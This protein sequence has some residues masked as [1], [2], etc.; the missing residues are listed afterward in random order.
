MMKKI[1]K[2]L[3]KRL[4][5]GIIILFL[6]GLSLFLSWSLFLP[7]MFRV[8]DYVHAARIT[9]V[10][11][12]LEAGHFPVRWSD[13]F[14]F[15]YGMP[16][17]LFYA[18]LPYYFGSLMYWLSENLIFAVKSLFFVA[19]LGSVVGGYLLGSRLSKS[20]LGGVIGAVTFGF[21]PYRALN[22]FVRGAVSEAWAMMFVIWLW[23]GVI[24]LLGFK[25]HQNTKQSPN[26]SKLNLQF[27]WDWWVVL[28]SAVGIM[29]SH[30]LTTLM[31]FSSLGVGLI[32]WI[33]TSIPFLSLF[34]NQHSRKKT[35]PQILLSIFFPIFKVSS[36]LLLAGGLAS[37]Y[38][39]PMFT[40][41]NLIR[42]EVFL[43]GYFD[44]RLHFLYIRQFFDSSWGYGGST[45]GPQ[46]DISF[47]LGWPLF[48]SIFVAVITGI[49]VVVKLMLTSLQ[50]K[51]FKIR[52]LKV[53]KEVTTGLDLKIASLM[54]FV[55]LFSLFLTLQRS[56]I[57]WE[58]LP[59]V[60]NIQFPWRWLS[61]ATTT[62]TSV[63]V[64][65]VVLIK[66]SQLYKK[67]VLMLLVTIVCA[68][69]VLQL[70]YFVPELWLDYP[71]DLY[72][73]N[74]ER[75]QTHMSEIMLDYVPKTAIIEGVSKD[76]PIALSVSES[77]EPLVINP[78]ILD[79]QFVAEYQTLVDDPHQK[80]VA[81]STD[82]SAEI[83]F[84][85]AD[86]QGWQAYLNSKKVNKEV[87]NSGLIFVKV[88]AGDHQVGIRFQNTKVRNMADIITAVSSVIILATLFLKITH[89]KHD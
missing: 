86:F 74:P 47:F 87:T 31:A 35:L 54:V 61:V 3:S 40:E 79:S 46:D 75:I 65:L 50:T 80:L 59:L 33:F 85:T 1:S 84:S 21:A 38:L 66:N 56:S 64:I 11:A 25:N 37:F 4:F 53:F 60:E 81:L 89:K 51:Q 13:H 22:L 29:L 16:L 68:G 26:S 17:F 10:R 14:G 28:F 41:K 71:Q 20:R 23:Y 39:I 18:P 2:Q 83:V 6:L 48:L 24:E 70:R 19:N 12:G 58:L 36:A 78:V 32:F 8:H 7:G 27:G 57:F 9:E 77:V 55:S 30:N 67:I 43:S 45:W 49:L 5:L 44:F 82:K 42:T 72:Y 73:S 52:F 69:G 62:L 88:P 34:Q 76:D 63:T 15:G